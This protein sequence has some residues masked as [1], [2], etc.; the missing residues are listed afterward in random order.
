MGGK[1]MEKAGQQ[2]G[3]VEGRRVHDSISDMQTSR[4]CEEPPA[5]KVQAPRRLIAADASDGQ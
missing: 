2:G 3:A 1:A 4:G 5:K